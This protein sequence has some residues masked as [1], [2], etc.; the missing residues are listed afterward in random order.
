MQRAPIRGERL[1]AACFVTDDVFHHRVAVAR[2]I[3]ERP[4]GDGANVLLELADE[5]GLEARHASTE[6][7]R[8][9][10][11]LVPKSGQSNRQIGTRGR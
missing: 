6:P 11:A 10:T 5:A 4:A 2:R 9:A 1:P 7:L 8:F 3:A